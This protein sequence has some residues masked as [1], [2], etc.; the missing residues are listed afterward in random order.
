MKFSRTGVAFV[1]PR[2]SLGKFVKDGVIVCRPPKFSEDGEYEVSLALNGV[3]FVSE[4]MTIMVYP[5]PSLVSVAPLLNDAR[6]ILNDSNGVLDINMV[7]IVYSVVCT[8]CTIYIYSVFSVVY[9]ILVIIIYYIPLHP[10]N[11]LYFQL[12]S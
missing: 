5:E 3:D 2:S 6:S 12:Y 7:S 9:S 4:T 1:P 11:Y 8:V 10:S